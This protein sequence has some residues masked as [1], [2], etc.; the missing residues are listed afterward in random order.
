M[1]RFRARTGSQHF[2]ILVCPICKL[3]LVSCARR[4]VEITEIRHPGYQ[5]P[6]SAAVLPCSRPI[7]LDDLPMRPARAL[8]G[9]ALD[10]PEPFAPRQARAVGQHAMSI[11]TVI[12]T[13]NWTSAAARQRDL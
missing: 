12:A 8:I 6:Q 2:N 4:A 11:R 7:P 5:H 1:L 9:D 3:E 10:D 13:L